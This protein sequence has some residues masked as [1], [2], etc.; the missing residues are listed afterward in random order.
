MQPDCRKKN[1]NLL[2]RDQEKNGRVRAGCGRT[3]LVVRLRSV[4][5]LWLLAP[6]GFVILRVLVV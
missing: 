6:V 2:E 3:N 1:S 5:S 4:L